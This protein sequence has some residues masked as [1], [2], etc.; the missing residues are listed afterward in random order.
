MKYHMV[1]MQNV[2]SVLT[3]SEMKM[4]KMASTSHSF[5]LYSSVRNAG[6]RSNFPSDLFSV[7]LLSDTTYS[8]FKERIKFLKV[9][10]ILGKLWPNG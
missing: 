10:E 4:S 9:N 1:Q 7:I 2:F 3:H 8:I 6:D 5:T